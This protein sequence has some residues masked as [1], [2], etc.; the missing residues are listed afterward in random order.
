M[1]KLT[2]IL[3]WA[4][5]LGGMSACTCSNTNDFSVDNDDAEVVD[6]YPDSKYVRME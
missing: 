2:H 4:L 3:C 5:L 1:I 6:L